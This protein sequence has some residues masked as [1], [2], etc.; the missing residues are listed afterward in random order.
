MQFLDAR[1][2]TGPNLLSGRVGA[3]LDI[4]CTPAEAD[5]L[6]PYCEQQARKMLDAVEW[7]A[8]SVCHVR[9]SGGVSV[10]FSAPIDA[11]YAASAIC[12][13]LWDCCDAEFNNGVA[14]EFAAAAAKLRADIE[15][16][17]NPPLRQLERAAAQ[18]NVSFLRDDDEVSL[19][20]GAG[21]QTWPVSELP[22]PKQL[23]WHRYHE[24]PV[25]IVTGTNGKTSS[26]RIAKH[27]LQCA[28]RSVG[29]S[30]TDWVSVNDRIIDR[31]D[32]SGPGGARLVLR[33]Q[34]VDVGI[35]ETARGGLLRR[36]LGVT[37]AD[38]ALITNIAEDH[39]GD[40]GS[41]SLDELLN[42]KWI[43]SH[44]VITR[45]DLIL[46]AEDP[47][48]VEK[49]RTYPGRVIYFGLREDNPV[50]ADHV[51][52]NGVAYVLSDNDLVRLDS[53]KREVICTA[54]EIPITLGGA[55]RHNV[56]NCLGAAALT[57]CL[58][59]SVQQIAAG[60]T[61]MSQLSNP[62]RGNLYE[63][64]GFK[65]LVDFA[66]NPQAMRALFSMATAL[67]AKR[68]ALCFG[69]AGDRTDEQIRKLAQSAWS[70]GLDLVNISELGK[71]A[72]GRR[73]GEV[74]AI[75]RDELL[76]LGAR[77]D[78]VRHFG[79]ERES[80]AAALAWAKDGDLVV[81]LDLG[82]NSDMQSLLGNA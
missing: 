6:I 77:D 21:S 80:F 29:L 58:G 62:G 36:G 11:L 17:S 15:S 50:I 37:R 34:D 28:G 75:M 7:S 41:Q 18:H 55:A 2:L 30:C 63:I 82:R 5:H 1:R 22:D 73:H 40:F 3:I 56:S 42:I 10:A 25:G 69:Q 31:D 67:P 47:L 46:N 4:A 68:R 13:W 44:A 64:G 24:I 45:G 35:L 32:W 54:S 57:Q 65:V 81:I 26:V 12:E 66:H 60:L 74:Y 20:L 9:L 48:L 52:G 14:T 78:Q 72:R 70:I 38:A 27:I 79:T 43:V 51:A 8:E 39:L 19:G 53:D 59:M 23:D 33:R 71:Y 76:R 16:E 49:V 61:S